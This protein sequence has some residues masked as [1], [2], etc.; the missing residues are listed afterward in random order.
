MTTKKTSLREKS[1]RMPNIASAQLNDRFAEYKNQ[2]ITQNKEAA[3]ALAFS[4]L[5]SEWYGKSEP[6]LLEDYLKG[7]EKSVTITEGSRIVRGEIDALYGNLIIEFENDVNA[8]AK[9][10]HAK[11]QLQGYAFA[12][13]TQRNETKTSYLCI[14][15][16]GI[17]FYVYS[18]YWKNIVD[19]PSSS[20]DIEL[21]EIEKVDFRSLNGEQAYLWIDRYFF[22][23]SQLHPTTEEFVRDFGM[24]SPSYVYA[25]K[26]LR[27][28]WH[29][30]KD[31]N[32]YKVIFENWSKYLL[33]VYG[34]SVADDELFL[35]HTYLAAFAKLLAYMRL[36]RKSVVPTPAEVKSIYT[37]KFFDDLGIGNFLEEDFFSWVTRAKVE[38]SLI[39]MARRISTLL[40][41]Y[42]LDEISEDVLKS[43]Y[44]ELVDPQTRHD[45][46]EF[47]TPDWLA[48][49]IVQHALKDNPAASV[50]DPSCGSGSFLYFAVRYKKEHGE[51]KDLLAH[52]RDTV[53]GIDIHPLAVIIAK[54]NYLLALGDLVRKRVKDF[55]IPV[56]LADSLKV[57]E[58]AS[59]LSTEH[60]VPS[61]D[62]ELDNTFVPFPEVFVEH[63]T[64]FDEAVDA[65]HSFS[66]E[67]SKIE[68]TEERFRKYARR[69]IDIEVDDETFDVLLS[70]ARR[71]RDLIDK[72]RN[73]IWT[74]ILK[75]VYKPI[76]LR[77][78]RFDWILGNPPWLSY[79]YVEKGKYQEFL[80]DAIV[81]TYGLVGKDEGHLITHL[82]LAT[83]FFCASLNHYG[84]RGSQVGFVLPRSIFSAD[85]HSNFRKAS[86]GKTIHQTGI[87][88]VWDLKNVAPLFNVPSCVVFGKKPHFTSKPIQAT[89]FEG[90]LQRR[91]ASMDEA[92]LQIRKTKLHVVTQGGRSYWAEDPKAEFSGSSPYAS[93]FVEGATIVPR[94]C[95]FV[96]IQHEKGLGI[97]PAEPF[98][99]TDPRATEQAK[100]ASADIEFEGKIEKD[101]LYA[102]LLSTDLL[103][104]GFLNYRPVVLPI[105]PSG[106]RFVMLS[107]DQLH[108]DGF[109]EVASWV[110]N[111]EKEWISRRKEKA[112]RM[113][114]YQRLDHLRGLTRQSHLAKFKVVYPMSATNLCSAVVENTKIVKRL[115][116]QKLVLKAFVADYKLFFYETDN[117]NEA[118]YLSAILNSPTIDALIKPMQSQGL[119]GPRDICMKVWELPIPIYNEERSSHCALAELGIECA[120]KVEKIIPTLDTRDVTPGKIG[121]LR[122]QVR[123][124]LKD[125]LKE[126]DGIVKKVM[127]K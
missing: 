100:E 41:R 82:E 14:A 49:R 48:D 116:D 67:H 60:K 71:M 64:A 47:Y 76:F 80:R 22:R 121:R 70:V 34:T 94:S 36:A 29:R 3:K 44:Q 84:K 59:Q 117:A 66:L 112:S 28:E 97:N 23:K 109:S 55:H 126:I 77:E 106:D 108:K 20:T 12:L 16:D 2:I 73:S 101:F 122:S 39:E 43:L 104:F 31:E 13:I 35:R 8:K 114:I 88:E 78:S 68:F 19:A 62:V 33:I 17:L 65:C 50:L 10:N 30:V 26:L 57:P 87:T 123:E 63:P 83:L 38:K 51:E 4:H 74:F 53:V 32:E 125:E 96:E 93:K 113:T 56:Y 105:K 92:S 91:N 46:G 45:L 98:V 21:R 107:V 61:F 11:E 86:F 120:K 75:N 69:R 99:K 127:G 90:E 5:F 37:G 42:F 40:E 72:K 102:S 25:E 103:P 24:N 118:S 9:L 89:V 95:W 27:T 119:W 1:T 58:R 15:S 124:Q 81:K 85:Q 6:T 7:T 110:E 52:I 18:P 79:R 115:G 111:C 54:T